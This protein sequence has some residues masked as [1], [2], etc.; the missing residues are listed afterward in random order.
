MGHLGRRQWSED[1]DLVAC[2]QCHP[3]LA[4]SRAMISGGFYR[5][6]NCSSGSSG[7][8]GFS[9]RRFHLLG[10]ASLTPV[11]LQPFEGPSD[12]PE[13]FAT[14]STSHGEQT[15]GSQSGCSRNCPFK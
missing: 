9:H 2:G 5:E 7:T 10:G 13:P 12:S 1:K 4:K 6:S 15:Q 3:R 11:P 8:G 14:T